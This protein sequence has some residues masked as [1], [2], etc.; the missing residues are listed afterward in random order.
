M[1]L[2]VEHCVED[3][4]EVLLALAE[5]LGIFVEFTGGP[6]HAHVLLPPLGVLAG[7][8]ES[9]VRDKVSLILII[10]CCFIN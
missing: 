1:L 8:E 4:D 5:E 3:E 6:E 9:V 2:F 10:W 7:V